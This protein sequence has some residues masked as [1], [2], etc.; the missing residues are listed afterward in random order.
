MD[1]MSALAVAN[2]AIATVRKIAKTSQNARHGVSEVYRELGKYEA[3]ETVRVNGVA[4][5]ES[6]QYFKRLLSRNLQ[7]QKHLASWLYESVSKI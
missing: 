4:M 7:L 2:T 1:V 5:N 6:Q 3:V